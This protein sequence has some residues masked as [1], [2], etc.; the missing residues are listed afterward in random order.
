MVLQFY[1][2]CTFER[3]LCTK[4]SKWTPPAAILALPTPKLAPTASILEPKV[5]TLTS[6]TVDLAAKAANLDAPGRPKRRSSA[7]MAS[8]GVQNASP[9]APEAVRGT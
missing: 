7:N 1:S 5:A 9:S 6:Q 2:F 4:P 3:I 8:L